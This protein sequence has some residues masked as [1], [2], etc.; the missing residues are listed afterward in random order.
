MKYLLK[1]SFIL[2]CLFLYNKPA[3]AL[4]ISPYIVETSSEKGQEGM[5]TIKIFNDSN[6]VYDVKAYAHD[7]GIDKSGKKIHKAPGGF[8]YSTAKY[9]DVI[10]KT[11]VLKAN[12]TREV[13]ILMKA[14]QDWT[15]GKSAIVFFDAKDEILCSI[16]IISP[17]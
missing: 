14:P 9:I 2:L 6:N 4:G 7:I 1:F 11:F 8:D 17:V 3:S 15:G 5:Q 13:K 16:K 10:P 12:E